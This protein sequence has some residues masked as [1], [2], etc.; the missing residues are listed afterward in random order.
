MINPMPSHRRMAAAV[1]VAATS[2]VTSACF[3]SSGADARSGPLAEAN[4]QPSPWPSA[5]VVLGHSGVNGEGTPGNPLDNSWAAGS[6]PDVDSVYL[7]ILQRQPAIDGHATNLAQSGATVADVELQVAQ[8]LELD[9]APELAIVQVVDN[10]MACPA[11]QGDYAAFRND[12]AELLSRISNGLPNA[13]VFIPTFY[14]EPSSYI[15][16]LTKSQ[17]QAVGGEGP[18]AIV[19][20]DGST[21]RVELRRLE[22]IIE[23]YDAAI[24]DACK[25]TARCAHDNGAFE[26][27]RLRPGD[28][29]EDL[30]HL[31]IQGHALAAKVAWRQLRRAGVLPAR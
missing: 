12:L 13:R 24:I 6:N 26:R 2:L 7:R 25:S 19:A 18:C 29:A 15:A 28:I 30:S 11:T 20:S 14:A 4:A 31:S 16:S 21:N 23:G 10:D 9:P 1:F 5:M 3:Q 8:A 22:A 27:T 17:R